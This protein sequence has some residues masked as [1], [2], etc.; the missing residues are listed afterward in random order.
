MEQPWSLF[1]KKHINN[2]LLI[3][4]FAITDMFGLSEKRKIILF[5]KIQF[6]LLKI[7]EWKG[8]VQIHLSNIQ[9]G[10]Y[11]WFIESGDL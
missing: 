8:K 3:F 11:E 7:K 4:S 6:F 9:P 5:E 1:R 2:A 10:F